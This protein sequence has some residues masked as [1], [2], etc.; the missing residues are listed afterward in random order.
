[1]SDTQRKGGYLYNPNTGFTP[2]KSEVPNIEVNL[3]HEEL[4]ITV[5]AIESEK[6][7]LDASMTEEEIK[8]RARERVEAL[9]EEMKLARDGRVEE[10]QRERTVRVEN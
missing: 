3:S 6:K 1:M 7:E 5:G 9:N 4:G 10:I 8:T 2:G